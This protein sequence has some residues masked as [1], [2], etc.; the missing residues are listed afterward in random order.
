MFRRV[1]PELMDH[2]EDFV[3]RECV[4]AAFPDLDN[5][6]RDPDIDDPNMEESLRNS[7]APPPLS[8]EEMQRRERLSAMRRAQSQTFKIKRMTSTFFR[9]RSAKDAIPVGASKSSLDLD[10]LANDEDDGTCKVCFDDPATIVLL[11]CGHGG[12]CQGCAKDLVLSGKPCYI[13]GEEYHMLA[14]L[15]LK[16]SGVIDDADDATTGKG[17][18]IGK[19]IR[20]DSLHHSKSISANEPSPPISDS[21]SGSPPAVPASR[22]RQNT[23]PVGA[24]GVTSL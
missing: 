9:V 2:V 24:G 12:L 8:L 4:R 5:P 23:A 7:E 17:R 20:P 11:P 1:P 10:D 3:C 14:E 22:M 13:C 19:L 16:S 6:Q 15:K 18:F 21:S